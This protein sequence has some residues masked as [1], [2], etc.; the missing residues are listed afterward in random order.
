[1]SIFKKWY[2]K[3]RLFKNKISI[4]FFKG[5]ITIGKRVEFNQP[6]SLYN[7]K[8]SIIIGNDCFLE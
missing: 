8:G 6:L 2:K 4:Y 3:Y 1:M 5:D 7:E